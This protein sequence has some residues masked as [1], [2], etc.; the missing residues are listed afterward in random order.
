MNSDVV[1]RAEGLG[2]CYKIGQTIDYRR[3]LRRLR[4]RRGGSS[5]QG[6]GRAAP[7][8]SGA[9]S[10][11]LNP[12]L[13][14]DT[15][16]ALRD[17][18]LEVKRG[19][20]IGIVGRNGAG[21]STLLKLLTR[22]TE[23]SEGWAEIHGRVGSLLEVGT[24]FN[25]ELTGRENVYMNGSI[26]GMRKREIDAKFDEIVAFSECEKFIDTPVKRYSSGMSVR[27]AF[28]VAAY[29]D[30]EIL[31]V[32]EVLAV[33]DAA[34]QK[35]CLGK[36][37]SV[38]QEGRTIL[39]VSHNMEVIRRLCSIGVYLS[40]GRI[41]CIETID[42]AVERYLE[43]CGEANSGCVSFSADPSVPMRLRRVAIV[44]NDGTYESQLCRGQDAWI[45]AEYDINALVEHSHVICHIMN[46]TE[47]PVV[48]TADSD[49][50]ASALEP[51]APGH[52]RAR[53]RLPTDILN[54]GHYT[55]SF[56]MGV[57]YSS[58]VYR[59]PSVLRF[60]LHD[61]RDGDKARFLQKRPGMI[62]MD[63]PWETEMIE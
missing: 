32:D 20:V 18:N 6:E 5:R 1:I 51:R 45:E 27:L 2:K 10:I 40:Q 28:A 56:S 26:L 33:G 57:P 9:R 53:F 4:G 61:R 49:V 54:E 60:H 58:V 16:W 11:P 7:P 41:Q 34:F 24:G 59:N 22:I 43:D 25:P 36:M 46:E 14:E 42:E 3:A 38:S 52:Y 30:P 55:I 21:K 29:L 31:L 23:P 37:N 12:K 19:E 47:T 39:F 15:F 50:D 63:I 62:L 48:S 44:G 17:I 35:K 8:E 13:R